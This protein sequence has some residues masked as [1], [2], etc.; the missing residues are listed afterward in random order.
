M[1]MMNKT[2]GGRTGFVK[3]ST[4][5][6]LVEAFHFEGAEFQTTA[7][8]W[9]FVPKGRLVKWNGDGY[10]ESSPHNIRRD[11]TNIPMV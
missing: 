4:Y 2:I 9:A 11:L 8:S 1:T 6:I 5:L 7:E 3:A 10:N